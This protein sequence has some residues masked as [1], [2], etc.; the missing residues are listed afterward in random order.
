MAL[1]LRRDRPVILR[2]PGRSALAVG[3][4]RALFAA[5]FAPLAIA[6]SAQAQTYGPGTVPPLTITTGTPE[7]VGN[8]RITATGT[9]HAVQVTGGTLTVDMQ[10]GPSPGAIV[11]HP[12]P[13]NRGLEISHEVADGARSVILDQVENGVA[14]R[15]AI[16]E[17]ACA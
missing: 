16:L 7:I 6:P 9:T 3:V 5:M 17:R 2:T 10:R 15:M 12:G 4:S 8:A 14:V 11:L 1:S 13:I